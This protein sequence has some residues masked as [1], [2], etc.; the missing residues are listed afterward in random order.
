MTLREHDNST[1][2]YIQFTNGFPR[3]E[4]VPTQGLSAGVTMH[5]GFFVG[6]HDGATSC[7][8]KSQRTIPPLAK[9]RTN[10]IALKPRASS[11]RYRHKNDPFNEHKGTEKTGFTPQSIKHNKPK[12]ER[13]S[14][15]NEHSVSNATLSVKL[16]T[17]LSRGKHGFSMQPHFTCKTKEKAKTSVKCSLHSNVCPINPKAKAQQDYQKKRHELESLLKEHNS[18]VQEV[19]QLNKDLKD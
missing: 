3:K 17:R 15:R 19:N 12:L 14:P 10:S 13:T 2:K 5:G 8:T 16:G 11:S 4:M 6:L 9:R 18:I 7:L 1:A